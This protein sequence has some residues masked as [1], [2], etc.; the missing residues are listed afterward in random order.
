LR[1]TRVEATWINGERVL[2]P[3]DPVVWHAGSTAS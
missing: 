1:S 3:P 2:V